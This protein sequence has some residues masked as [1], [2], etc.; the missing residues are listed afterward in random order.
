MADHPAQTTQA[1]VAAHVASG[2]PVSM[3]HGHPPVA[4]GHQ[5]REPHQGDVL[6]SNPLRHLLGQRCGGPGR[7]RQLEGTSRQ[8]HIHDGQLRVGHSRCRASACHARPRRRQLGSSSR[9]AGYD[10]SHSPCRHQ[11]GPGP[12]GH[13]WKH[14]S[15]EQSQGAE[16]AALAKSVM[17]TRSSPRFEQESVWATIGHQ[18]HTA[19]DQQELRSAAVLCVRPGPAKSGCG[20]ASVPYTCPRP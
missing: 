7:C 12:G 14:H 20:R 1:G 5:A 18:Y 10:P 19:A 2:Q 9:M 13:R 17:R 15:Y 8:R 3:G 16:P 6:L 4:V 11:P